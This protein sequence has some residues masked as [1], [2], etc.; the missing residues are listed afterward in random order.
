MSKAA[1]ANTRY[2][3][4][5]GKVLLVGLQFQGTSP[6]GTVVGRGHRLSVIPSNYRHVYSGSVPPAEIAKRR[7]AA[8]VGRKQ[9]LRNRRGF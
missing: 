4:N 3:T 5:F 6:T 1:G 9:N 7:K 2:Q 8:K